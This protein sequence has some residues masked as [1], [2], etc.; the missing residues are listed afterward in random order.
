MKAPFA[1]SS[2][3]VLEQLGVNFDEGLSVDEA[4]RR[5]AQFGRNRIAETV[6][7]PWW[8]L[9]L[10][11]F[12]SP[13]VY[14]LLFATALSFF[15]NEW[16]DGIAI[17]MVILI[18]AVIGFLMEFQAGQSMEALRQLSSISA[19]VRRGG[20]LLEINA[21][22][23]VS[24]D[25]AFIETGDVVAAD[26]RIIQ[27]SQL[28]AD[29]AS[30]TG[31][32]APVNKI[33]SPVPEGTLL[34]DRRN[35]LFKGTYIT[36]GNAWMVVTGSGMN[37][38]LGNIA[39]LVEKAEQS[40]TPLEKKLQEFSKQL[41]KITIALVVIIFFAGWMGGQDVWKM[42]QTSIALAVAAIP[43]GLPIVA[44]IGLANGM[45]KMAR[46]NVIVRRLSAVE[47]LGGTNVICTDKTGTL[48]ENRMTVVDLIEDNTIH[49]RILEAC[50]LCNTAEI[51]E[52]GNEIGDPLETALLKYV[53]SN[54]FIESVRKQH[55]KLKEDPFSSETKRMA[56]AHQNDSG[57]IV[58]AKGAP[59]EIIRLCERVMEDHD[60]INLT[61]EHKQRLQREA[62]EL[63]ARGYKVLAFAFNEPTKMPDDLYSNLVFLGF[64]SLID[65][66][67]EHIV[68]AIEECRFAGIKV[69]M[70][71]GDHAATAN[72]I[73]RQI[74][75]QN[76]PTDVVIGG[77]SMKPYEQLTALDKTSWM[78]AKVFAR[79][80]PSQKL[81]LVK[82]FQE[83][84]FVV[85]MTGDGV[86]DA[87]ALKKADIGIAM[88]LRG[89]QV[90]QDV[91]D[92]VLKDDSFASI[93]AA[94]REGRII[95]ENIRKFVIFLLSCNL[96]ELMI[97][98]TA[99]ILNLHFQLFP[100]QILFIN[101]I[102][103]VLPALALGMTEGDPLI[104]KK[105]PR[106]MNE[107]IIDSQ[108]WKAV[109]IYSF[110]ITVSCMMAVLVSHELQH[111]GELITADDCNNILFLSLIGTQLL[112]AFNMNSDERHFFK[113]EVFSNKYIWYALVSC[114]LVIVGIYRIPAVAKV[115][116][117]SALSL[118]DIMI[119]CGS[120]V[121]SLIV[122]Q[123]IK[124]MG[125]AKQ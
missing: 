49:P 10:Q 99:S 63:A 93:V 71:T 102:T 106:Q 54:S 120:S 69:L 60:T 80:T 109:F 90:A 42:L 103:D 13:L 62:S 47:T 29:E 9:L 22:E 61:E 84:K 67:R 1:L 25:V 123:L 74:G 66:P 2:E 98:A 37:S 28:Q 92:M 39:M 55:P 15:F 114:L 124:T 33:S 78:N 108:R 26:G 100:L 58:F 111:A 6:T 23:I 18:N 31:E 68:T 70:V 101:I 7:D 87:P 81:D 51:D 105:E 107:P 46:K 44:T 59:E 27:Q 52:Q 86:N 72:E 36:K 96:S 77:A 64:V 110:I 11:Q 119:I 8:R 122:I 17:I 5:L 112:H 19:K 115:L 38:E 50:I 32:S 21:E 89:T 117:F 45:I 35:M 116:S 79:V 16:L 97:I 91:A 125:W 95:F 88:G 121:F 24:G 56:S 30:L 73:A 94:I 82:V 57:V 104:M 65:P 40:A 34:A 14:L 75:I 83:S 118:M 20:R 4:A 48:T 41:I 53:Q 12:K 76:S 43:E 113:S 3:E 85:G